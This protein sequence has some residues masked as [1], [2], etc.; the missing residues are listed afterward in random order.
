VEYSLRLL[1]AASRNEK[2]DG[3]ERTLVYLFGTT[4]NGESIAVKTPLLMP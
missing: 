3:K 4:E 1:T 2:V